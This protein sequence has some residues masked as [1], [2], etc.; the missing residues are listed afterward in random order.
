MNKIYLL[1]QKIST[2]EVILESL[3]DELIDQELLDQLE[4]DSKI[5]TKIKHLNNQI[6]KEKE[7]IE[8]IDF[9]YWGEKGEA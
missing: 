5:L 3:I 6:E 4:L 9:P 2:L 8:I 1:E 7:E